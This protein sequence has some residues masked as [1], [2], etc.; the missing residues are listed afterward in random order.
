ML[1]LPV[2]TNAVNVYIF[3]SEE[4]KDKRQKKKKG[5]RKTLRHYNL[6]EE[7]EQKLFEYMKNYYLTHKKVTV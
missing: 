3:F 6:P 1:F 5:P 4:E 7:K 2:E